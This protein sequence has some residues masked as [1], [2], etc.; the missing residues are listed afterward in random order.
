LSLSVLS[1]AKVTLMSETWKVHFGLSSCKKKNGN[2]HQETTYDTFLPYKKWHETIHDDNK[3]SKNFF[4]SENLTH[5]LMEG[6]YIQYKCRFKKFSFKLW[7]KTDI[8]TPTHF[9]CWLTSLNGIYRKLTNLDAEKLK[10][11][12]NIKRH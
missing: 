6:Y 11:V 9:A 4:W 7:Q 10:K 2:Q 5:Q 1:C 12:N 3:T 8:L